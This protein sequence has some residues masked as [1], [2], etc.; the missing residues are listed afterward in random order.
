MSDTITLPVRRI[1]ELYRALNS[2]DA[3]K[4]GHDE[5]VPLEFSGLVRAKIV[6]NCVTLDPLVRAHETTDRLLS[7]QH[8]VIVDQKGDTPDS[9]Q[10]MDA[11]LRSVHEALDLQR[12]VALERI[13]LVDILRRP[14][15]P[16]NQKLN[17][18]PQSVIN[19]LA[20]ILD[21]DGLES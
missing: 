6:A 20:P 8:G 16:K 7:K 19:R 2:L 10:A 17:P 18:V 5:I 15:D 9:A 13:R 12:D 11:Y 4:Q 3:V 21:F 1:L 14:G